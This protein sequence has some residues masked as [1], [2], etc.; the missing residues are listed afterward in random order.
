MLKIYDMAMKHVEWSAEHHKVI[1][2]LIYFIST[3]LIIHTYVHTY[4]HG[5]L[6]HTHIIMIHVYIYY[7]YTIS[8]LSTFQLI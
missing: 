6:L 3:L 2:H 5:L 1:A 4:I 7:T 8:F